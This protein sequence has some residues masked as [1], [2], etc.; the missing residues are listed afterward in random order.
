MRIGVPE[1]FFFDAGV[2]EPD[3]LAAVRQAAAVFEALGAVVGP[4]Q[5][6]DPAVYADGGAFLADAGA[7]HEANLRDRPED[8]EPL[9]RSRLQAA[10]ET[11][12]TDYSR[13]RF[14][15]YEMK[16]AV[17]RLFRDVD[18]VLTPTCPIVAPEVA[19]PPGLPQTL[20]VR[21]TGPFNTTGGPVISLPCGFSPDGLPVGLSLAGRDWDEA[22]V[23]RA[24]HAFQQA[25]DWHRRL[26]PL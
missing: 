16:R 18:L 14:K 10:L 6:P 26:P 15:Q 5:Y 25:T 22:L 1:N 23:L 24:A 12:A 21:N 7:Y 20:L 13:A 4:V 2:S 9:I 11:R 17:Q 8:Y 19:T 3:V